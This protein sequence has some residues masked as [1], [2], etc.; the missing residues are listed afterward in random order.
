MSATFLGFDFGT[1]RIGVA[2]GQNLTGTAQGIDTINNSGAQGP[3]PAIAKLV[4]E[5]QPDALVVG[6]PLTKDGNE[7]NLAKSVRAFAVK[8]D[9]RFGLPVHFIDE[10]L[11]SQTA[12]ALVSQATPVGKRIIGK[13]QSLRDQIAAELILSTYLNNM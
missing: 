8:L 3:W 12:E 1:R 9:Q 11:T 13:R 5:W 6:L 2:V 4:K 7:T 10:T